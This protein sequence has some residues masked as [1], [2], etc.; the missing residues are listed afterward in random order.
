MNDYKYM[1]F[2]EI[3]DAIEKKFKRFKK[4]EDANNA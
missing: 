2:N 4:M 3:A 1:T